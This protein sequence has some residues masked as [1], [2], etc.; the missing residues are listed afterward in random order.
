MSSWERV[1]RGRAEIAAPVEEV[2]AVLVDLERYPEW[3]PFT[4]VVESSLE[5]GAPV[6]M[7]VNLGWQTLWQTETVLEVSP[8]RTL[9]WGIVSATPWLLRAERVQRLTPVEGGQG[10][11]Y[12]TVDTIAGLVAPLVGLLFGRGLVA[13][14]ADVARAL[15]ER[16][17]GG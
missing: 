6:K 3:N 14:F 1:Y 8:P 17:E 10:C 5:P 12:E 13:G 15:R 2:W 7:L 9:R 11:V 4:L 16:V